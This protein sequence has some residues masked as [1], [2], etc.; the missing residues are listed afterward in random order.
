EEQALQE[1]ANLGMHRTQGRTGVLILVSLFE[2][3]VIVLGDD[4]IHSKRG[5]E[6]WLRTDEAII[7][8]IRARSLAAGLHAG[9]E[10]VACVLAEKCP[11][12]EPGP[13]ELPDRLIVRRR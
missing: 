2:R 1:F 4:G 12:A 8:G 11:R 10:S 5:D 13:N 3:A 7:A 9:I 6:H